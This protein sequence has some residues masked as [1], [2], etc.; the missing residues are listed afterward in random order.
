MR[1][2]II[3]TGAGKAEMRKS[4]IPTG[5]GKGRRWVGSP[6]VHTEGSQRRGIQSLAESKQRQRV[7]WRY[8]T[9]V[10]SQKSVPSPPWTEPG[11]ISVEVARDA[12]LA[13]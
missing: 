7:A 4:V 6:R 9:D 5:A 11:S 1:K 10:R 13:Q 2:S 12:G 3:P 8:T